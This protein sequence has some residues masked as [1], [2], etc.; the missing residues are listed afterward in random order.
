MIIIG[1]SAV[2]T[3][4]VIIEGVRQSTTGSVAWLV[5]HGQS[6]KSKPSAG[7]CPCTASDCVVAVDPCAHSWF[8]RMSATP[9]FAVDSSVSRQLD[10][11]N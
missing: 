1:R 2:S 3:N 8:E 11:R 5:G 10:R 6:R 7:I 9:G 4:R